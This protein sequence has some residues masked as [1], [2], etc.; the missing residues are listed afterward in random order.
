MS[1]T[2]AFWDGIADRYAR[3]PIKD[4]VAYEHTLERT[5]AQLARTDRVLEV[6]C[7]T[8]STA[9][10][11]APAVGAYVAADL[12]TRMI[13]IARSKPQAAETAN[14]SFRVA[15]LGDAPLDEGAPYDAVL[16]FSLLHLLDDMP[17]GLARIHGLLKPGGTFVSKT[18]CLADFGRIWRV[19]I[20]AMRLVGLAPKVAFVS[21]DE[22]DRAI[23]E[24]GFEIHETGVFPEKPP[25]RFVAARKPSA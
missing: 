5:R 11:L 14:L 12:S 7:G 16:A 2:A 15:A 13:E 10:A 4:V 20:P 24:A 21:I 9:L 18:I 22:V 19:V 6:G 1:G 23:R 8:G 17:A 3:R 25:A